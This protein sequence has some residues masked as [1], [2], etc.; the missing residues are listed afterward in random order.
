MNIDYFI[1]LFVSLLFAWFLILVCGLFQFLEKE[2]EC[3]DNA[4][5]LTLESR[6]SLWALLGVTITAFGVVYLHYA[7]ERPA[8]FFHILNSPKLFMG[9]LFFSVGPVIE[10]LWTIGYDLV[11]AKVHRIDIDRR[12]IG[13]TY[14]WMS[15]IYGLGASAFGFTYQYVSDFDWYW[16]GVIYL[17]GIYLVEYMS[18][19]SLKKTIGV[20]PW[21][22]SKHTKYHIQGAIRLDYAP[23]WFVFGIAMELIYL[24]LLN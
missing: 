4:K 10:I 2:S 8:W 19:K 3:S 24:Q 23:A 6:V 9:I 16:R 5:L 18:A 15:P 21:D 7:S 20:I 1:A 14:L 17:I 13:T 12:L 22:Y 11:K